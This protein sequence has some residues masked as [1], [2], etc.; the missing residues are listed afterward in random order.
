MANRGYSHGRKEHVICT[1][2]L[3]A[4]DEKVKISVVFYKQLVITVAYSVTNKSSFSVTWTH[5]QANGEI[6]QTAHAWDFYNVIHSFLW[7]IESVVWNNKKRKD[8][9]CENSLYLF[10]FLQFTLAVYFSNW[11]RNIS[12]KKSFFY[13]PDTSAFSVT[14]IGD[15]FRLFFRHFSISL[16]Q[17]DF[18]I[19]L[20]FFSCLINA[21]F[22]TLLEFDC[23]KV[24]WAFGFWRRPDYICIWEMMAKICRLCMWDWGKR[25]HLDL[26]ND[27][28]QAQV[29]IWTFV[30]ETHL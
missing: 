22:E 19:P 9:I 26:R 13:K 28:S 27:T 16:S 23:K 14:C 30:T 6:C 4:T 1:L 12:W 24:R 10:L 17:I 25:H 2:P 5:P 15:I 3:C 8:W 29:A 21:P 7:K 20:A 18:L 11:S